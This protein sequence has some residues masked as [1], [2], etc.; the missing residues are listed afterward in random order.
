MLYVCTC[1]SHYIFM[2]L[3]CGQHRKK[4]GHKRILNRKT[5]RDQNTKEKSFS[6]CLTITSRSK[7]IFADKKNANYENMDTGKCSDGEN[8]HVGNEHAKFI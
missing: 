8:L 3:G 1:V 5:E 2:V 6:P 7:E 4:K